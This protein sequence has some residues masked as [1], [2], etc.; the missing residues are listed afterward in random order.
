M[1]SRKR[2]FTTNNNS[3][4]AKRIRISASFQPEDLCDLGLGVLSDDSESEPTSI[5]NDYDRKLAEEFGENKKVKPLPEAEMIYKR[6]GAEDKTLKVDF[7]ESLS[8]EVVIAILRN[9]DKKSLVA[10]SLTN[11]RFDRLCHDEEL[12]PRL[13]LTARKLEIDN[14]GD[15]L[16]TGVKIL[17]LNSAIFP[18]PIL[19][20]GMSSKLEHFVAKVKF[21]DLSNAW[22]KV[23]DLALLLSKMRN[24]IKLS[25]EDVRVNVDVIKAVAK[26]RNLETL[27]LAMA[28]GLD[29]ESVFLIARLPKLESLNVAWTGL[30][31]CAY[32]SLCVEM[33][34]TIKHIDISGSHLSMKNDHLLSL[35]KRCPSIESLDV[36]DCLTVSAGSLREIVKHLP[37]L[38]SLAISRCYQLEINALLPLKNSPKLET[39][40]AFRLIKECEMEIIQAALPSV[41]IN[42]NPLS[43]I[44]RP[45]VGIRRTSIWE[46][47]TSD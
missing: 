31:I 38:K 20:P 19:S 12:W 1:E 36:S 44:A 16:R 29:H 23:E 21:L 3:Y 13:N 27:N 9:L 4:D 42:K 34:P 45:T 17:R 46:Q 7:F 39:L 41:R 40:S 47:P 28:T 22:I 10:L 35:V 8:D 15:I 14:I 33:S 32:Q 6:K 5:Y 37:N 2:P 18:S 11:Q 24:L 26:N 30:E 43:V 25:L